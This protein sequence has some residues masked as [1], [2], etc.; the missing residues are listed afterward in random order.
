MVHKP[1][2]TNQGI[3]IK[4]HKS[5]HINLGI[6]TK[7]HKSRYIN[8]C[9]FRTSSQSQTILKFLSE[10]VFEVNV[11]CAVFFQF[12]FCHQDECIVSFKSCNDQTS[13][14]AE[15]TAD[16]PFFVRRTD[17]SSWASFNPAASELRFGINCQTLQRG[18]VCVLPRNSD[19][20]ERFN[21]IQR[22]GNKKS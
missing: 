12:I 19:V 14:Q 20:V 22:I 15:I 8:Q 13:L 16:H 5:W 21:G 10:D 2:Y 1:R 6:Q 7:M 9:K 17:R 3:Q 18:D 4:V 11:T